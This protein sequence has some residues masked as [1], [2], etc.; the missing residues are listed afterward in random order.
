VLFVVFFQ[1][2]YYAGRE[3]EPGVLQA[4]PSPRRFAVVLGELELDPLR[5]ERVQHGTPQ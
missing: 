2:A 5:N 4:H 1:V 3:A